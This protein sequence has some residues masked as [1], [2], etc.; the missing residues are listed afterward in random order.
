MKNGISNYIAPRPVTITIGVRIIIMR[1]SLMDILCTYLA[2]IAIRLSKLIS[3]LPDTCQSPVI[4]G[5]TDKASYTYFEYLDVLFAGFQA[6]PDNRH[7]GP[8]SSSPLS[9]H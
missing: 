6:R 5:F 2:S 7:A 8:P 3:D 4:P 9:T 1:S